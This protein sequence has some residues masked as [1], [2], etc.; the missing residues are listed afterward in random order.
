MIFFGIMHLTQFHFI[1]LRLVFLLVHFDLKSMMIAVISHIMLP[2][3]IPT[4]RSLKRHPIILLPPLY[5]DS[6]RLLT[7]F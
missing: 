5:S 2:C 7:L 6:H 4:D 3:D 1:I